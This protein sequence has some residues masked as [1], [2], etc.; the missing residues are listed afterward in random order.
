MPKSTM[1]PIQKDKPK[2]YENKSLQGDYVSIL[3]T[4]LSD[5]SADIRLQREGNETVFIHNK[6]QRD[7]IS[8][9]QDKNYVFY[10]VDPQKLMKMLGNQLKDSLD[11]LIQMNERKAIIPI[12]AAIKAAYAVD[13]ADKYRMNRNKSIYYFHLPIMGYNRKE[14]TYRLTMFAALY[15]ETGMHFCLKK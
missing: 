2:I 7:S 4:I 14:L 8:S 12:P 5:D 1:T 6:F 10:N 15:V 11:M 3:K 13:D 9:L